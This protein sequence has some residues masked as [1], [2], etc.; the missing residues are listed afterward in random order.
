MYGPFVFS[1]LQDGLDQRWDITLISQLVK[2]Y[3]DRH[4]IDIVRTLFF[5][6]GDHR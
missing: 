4:S 5:L 1:Q 2:D 3:V 6:I